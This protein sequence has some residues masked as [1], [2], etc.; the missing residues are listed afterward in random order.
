MESEEERIK[1]SVRRL[2]SLISGQKGRHKDV[3]PYV[4]ELEG[5][6]LMKEEYRFGLVELICMEEYENPESGTNWHKADFEDLFDDEP[7]MP[8]IQE[9]T[10][11]EAE[12]VEQQE[13]ELKTWEFGEDERMEAHDIRYHVDKYLNV[14]VVAYKVLLTK[15]AIEGMMIKARATE[16]NRCLGYNELFRFLNKPLPSWLKY[17]E[18]MRDEYQAEIGKAN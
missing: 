8:K 13:T 7:G 16:L 4:S 14:A 12:K 18:L 10:N 9:E 3:H 1:K 5:F 6:R 2:L 11:K 15:Q 17:F